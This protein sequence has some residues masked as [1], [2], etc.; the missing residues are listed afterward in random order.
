MGT[1]GKTV[2]FKF[3][4]TGMILVMPVPLLAVYPRECSQQGCTR[5]VP[6]AC[7]CRSGKQCTVTPTSHYLQ[8]QNARGKQCSCLYT[9]AILLGKCPKPRNDFREIGRAP[10]VL[11]RKKFFALYFVNFSPKAILQRTDLLSVILTRS[12]LINQLPEE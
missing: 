5:Y 1:F 7:A 11:I 8:Q 4:G 10:L 3:Y 9:R 6:Y 2:K 12:T